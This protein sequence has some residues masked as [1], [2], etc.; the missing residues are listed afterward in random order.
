FGDLLSLLLIGVIRRF[1]LEPKN[2]PNSETPFQEQLEI[3]ATQNF[4]VGAASPDLRSSLGELVQRGQ[5]DIPILW[6]LKGE[7]VG[8]SQ[9]GNR[10]CRLDEFARRDFF[11]LR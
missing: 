2:L 4:E 8:A 7:L 11:E 9:N 6:L 10:I 5:G 3:L 1:R